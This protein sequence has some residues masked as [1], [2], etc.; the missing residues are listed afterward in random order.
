MTN[1][2]RATIP[3]VRFS[4]IKDAVLGKKY[5]LNLIFTAPPKIR[6]L[7]NIYRGIDKA[8]DILSFPL[9]ASEGEVYISP[10]ET[11]KEAKNFD[12][13]YENFMAFLFIHGCVHLK[14]HDHSATME[15]I[16]AKFRKQFKV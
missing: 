9:S 4:S 13:P 16:E 3:R 2:T 14:G 1:E 6:K 8:T 11:R 10:S 7:N 5:K 12:R 15:R